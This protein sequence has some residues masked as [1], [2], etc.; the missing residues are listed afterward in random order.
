MSRGYTVSQCI[1][2]VF[3]NQEQKAQRTFCRENPS[4]TDYKIGNV[5]IRSTPLFVWCRGL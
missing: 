2:S 3:S 4:E 5:R 1:C